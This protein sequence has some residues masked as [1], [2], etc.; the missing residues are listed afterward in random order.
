MRE[1]VTKQDKKRK[2][3]AQER[4]SAN[5]SREGEM[6]AKR[7]KFMQ[8]REYTDEDRAFQE[9]IFGPAELESKRKESKYQKARGGEPRRRKI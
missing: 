9:G 5:E 3:D 2:E 4:R 7:V 8:E 1:W 6:I